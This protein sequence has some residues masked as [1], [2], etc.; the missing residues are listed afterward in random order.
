MSSAIHIIGCHIARGFMIPPAVV[1]LDKACNFFLQFIRRLPDI[2]KY[3]LFYQA[4]VSRYL[5]GGLGMICRGTDMTD[6][7]FVLA[8]NP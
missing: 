6:I 4:V 2:Q 8:E 7:R 5:T 1:P 3:T